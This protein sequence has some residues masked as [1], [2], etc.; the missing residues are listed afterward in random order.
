MKLQVLGCAGGIGG[1]ERFTTSLLVDDTILLD[2]GTGLTRLGVEQLARIDHVFIT[3]CHLDHVA[4]LALLVDAVQGKRSA[5]IT[6]HATEKIISSL[7]QH[8]FN[9]VLWPDFAAIPDT[10]HP[11][12]RWKTVAHGA[13]VELDG[14][15]L[16]SHPVNHTVGSA[17]YLVQNGR[18]GFLFTGDM[19]ST[20][21]LWTAMRLET[22]LSKVIVDCSFANADRELAAK[23]MHFCPGSLIEDLH[24]MDDRIEFLIYHLKPGQEDLI[25]QE[26]K[27]GGGGRPFRAL[28]CGDVFEF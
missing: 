24:A 4:G 9:W 16:T 21:E 27:A 12:L 19:A 7:K 15:R 3:H 14:R 2:A 28:K 22:K 11:A 6:V 18:S 8:L 13:T 10:E 20:P 1:R 23:S 26:L 25:M 17:A 5:P